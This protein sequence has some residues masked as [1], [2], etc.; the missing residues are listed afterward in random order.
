MSTISY[1]LTAPS[2]AL[3]L[4]TV[5]DFKK[6]PDKF[7]SWDLAVRII[8]RQQIDLRVI[9]HVRIYWNQALHHR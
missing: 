7:R 2:L 6:Q 4:Q 9:Y 8:S 5:H 3:I 1:S